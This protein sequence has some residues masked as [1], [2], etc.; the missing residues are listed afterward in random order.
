[1][2][3]AEKHELRKVFGTKVRRIRKERGLSQEA[4]ADVAGLHRTFVG[5]VERAETNVSIDNIGR[6]ADA[7]GVSAASLLTSE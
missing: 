1:M 4:L 6:I 2:S 5:F 3:G 7:L